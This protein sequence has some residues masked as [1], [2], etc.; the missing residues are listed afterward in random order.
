[1]N[2]IKNYGY[3]EN[4]DFID[5]VSFPIYIIIILFISFYIQGKYIKK[6]PEYKY[7]TTA[8]S[9]KLIGA[10]AFC[11]VYIFVYKGGDTILYFESSRA[12]SRL[13]MEKPDDFFKIIFEPASIENYYLFDGKTTGYPHIHFYLDPKTFLV[14]RILIPFMLLSFN[15]YMLATI[16]FSWISFFGIWKMYLIFSKLYIKYSNYIAYAVL[17][18]PSAIFWGSGILK[19]TIT[20]SCSCWFIYGFYNFF[21]AKESRIKNLII[22]IIAS[23]IILTIKS[24]ILLAL[25][26]GSAIWIFHEKIMRIR[27][28]FL[29]YSIIP[30]SI[31]MSFVIG[32]Y[33]MTTIG[34]TSIEKLLNDAVEKQTDLKR[35]GYGGNSFDIG[36]YEPT[37]SGALSVAPAALIASWYRPF[38]FE[39]K[40]VVMLL[41][42][43]ENFIYLMLTILIFKNLKIRKILKIIFNSPLL[44][45]L[46]SYSILLGLIIGLSTSNF[47][48]LVRFKIAFLPEFVVMLVIT[49]LLTKEKEKNI[50]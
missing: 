7:Y 45:F 5:Y 6:N 32:Y 19:D 50:H 2:E 49:Y 31:L 46:L 23:S 21:I 39:A 33:A 4:L 3:I 1:M 36:G 37:L 28:S 18:L 10:V 20:F 14:V 29:R 13:L 26:P 9:A 43:I 30:F 27:N 41:S 11:L 47:G 40:N 48:A 15:N 12:F 38:I 8:V 44:I 25:L 42:G 17:F 34:G 24:Y 16:I 22:L 35:E